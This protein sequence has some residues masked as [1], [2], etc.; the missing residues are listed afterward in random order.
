M[1][2]SELFD[3]FEIYAFRLEGL[4]HY[5]IPGREERLDMFQRGEELPKGFN[6]QWVE[7]ISAALSRGARM[8]RLRLTSDPATLYE[9]YET[10]AAYRPGVQVG[11]DI[12]V[13]LRGGH[14][15]QQDFWAFD[16]KWF[17]PM[18]YSENGEFIDATVLK[19]DDSYVALVKQWRSVWEK[20]VKLSYS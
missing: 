18:S 3:E 1:D 8:E 15:F 20:A 11:E 7:T 10:E 12:R 2:L 4:G 19:M 14:D 5:S 16:D 13:D 9:R 17:V 6:D